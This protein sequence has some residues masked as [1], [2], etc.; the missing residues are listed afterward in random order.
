M[1]K[2]EKFY[3]KDG[4]GLL[5]HIA[6]QNSERKKLLEISSQKRDHSN[7]IYIYVQQTLNANQRNFL[8]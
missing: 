5:E 7:A 4:T 3:R 1:M 6:A 8:A 2:Y